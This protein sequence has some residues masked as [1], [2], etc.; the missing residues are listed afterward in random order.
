MK[1]VDIH[2]KV[3]LIQMSRLL[4]QF[5]ELA[6]KIPEEDFKT[7]VL[8]AQKLDKPKKGILDNVPRG[9]NLPNLVPVIS[10][11]I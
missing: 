11:Q 9:V 2:S 5:M 4:V 8:T 7:I 1:D 10:R 3:L 6:D